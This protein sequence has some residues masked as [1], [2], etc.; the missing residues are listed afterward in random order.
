M[1]AMNPEDR[2]KTF[3]TPAVAAATPAAARV[4]FFKKLR[5]EEF[6]GG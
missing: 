3:S 1:P 6:N 5:L 4:E 2:E